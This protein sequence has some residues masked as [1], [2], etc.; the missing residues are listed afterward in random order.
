MS[1]NRTKKN[2][3]L[4]SLDREKKKRKNGVIR[5]DLL[6]KISFPA[7]LRNYI[8]AIFSSYIEYTENCWEVEIEKKSKLASFFRN[9]QQ[10]HNFLAQKITVENPQRFYFYFST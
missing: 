9:I 4:T 8:T 7:W 5:I 10:I 2:N 3:H 6:Q 1:T